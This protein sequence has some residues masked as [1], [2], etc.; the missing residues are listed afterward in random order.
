VATM[1]GFV[2]ARLSDLTTV[3]R[4]TVRARQLA[5][6]VASATGSTRSAV[7]TRQTTSPRPA[8]FVVRPDLPLIRPGVE[9]C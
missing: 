7:R 9:R 8:P 1:Q 5:R 4:L 2:R 6:A 3:G